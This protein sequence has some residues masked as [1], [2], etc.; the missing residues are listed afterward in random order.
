M[1]PSGA[2]CLELFDIDEYFKSTDTRLAQLTN[3]CNILLHSTLGSDSD[4][5]YYIR[6]CG[7]ILGLKQNVSPW[8]AKTILEHVID[9]II[10]W[11]KL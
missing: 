10:Q 7:E 9:Q 1:R 6:E 8:N 3:K 4:V 11:K 2:P 5:E